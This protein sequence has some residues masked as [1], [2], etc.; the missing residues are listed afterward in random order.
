MAE[1]KISLNPGD[2]FALYTDGVVESRSPE[3][4]EYGYDR[5][6][7]VLKAIRHEDATEIHRAVLEDLNTF[8]QDGEYDD[9]MTLV[10]LKWHGISIPE[11][12]VA[13]KREAESTLS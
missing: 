3:G 7:E 4:E 8:L 11:G 5:L 1:E 6:L 9:D 10:I 12:K 13:I 2:V